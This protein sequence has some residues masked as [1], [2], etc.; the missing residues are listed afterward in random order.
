MKENSK[1]EI[2]KFFTE[3]INTIGFIF[4]SYLGIGIEVLL[5][6]V[7]AILMSLI[8]DWRIGLVCIGI[9]FIFFTFSIAY[10]KINSILEVHTVTFDYFS[11]TIANVKLIK[12]FN[13]KQNLLN[14]IIEQEK[15]IKTR[16]SVFNHHAHIILDGVFSILLFSVIA[17]LYFIGGKFVIELKISTLSSFTGSSCLFSLALMIQLLVEKNLIDFNFATVSLTRLN[18]LIGKN[19]TDLNSDSVE[20][21]PE[22]A[23][24]KKI[25]KLE[26]NKTE[27]QQENN[28]NN[29]K[30]NILKMY[31]NP[32]FNEKSTLN[33]KIEIKDNE[34][35]EI[36][37]KIEFR[38]VSFS[39]SAESKT[40]VLN[41]ISFSIEPGSKVGFVG[42]SGSGKSTIISLLLRFF[43]PIEGEIFLDDINIKNIN[44]NILRDFFS[45]VFQ[46]PDLFERSIYENVKY[47]NLKASEEEIASAALIAQVPLKLLKEATNQSI[48]QISGGQKQRIAIARCLLKKRKIYFFDESTS[49]LDVNTEKKIGYNLDCYFNNMKEAKTQLHVVHR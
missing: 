29:H 4:K 24:S 10:L 40:K 7:S 11:E 22:K 21:F 20:I 35:T 45:G 16:N 34:I 9:I 17:L 13:L 14:F 8:F 44:A 39:Y 43:E 3:D 47:G 31:E 23:N 41:N 12:A 27:F 1:N 6:C 49:A 38:N 42:T 15:K 46:E 28:N 48:N 25:K 18:E 26:K 33:K 30:E 32:A 2:L 5:T 36:K 37:G 19:S